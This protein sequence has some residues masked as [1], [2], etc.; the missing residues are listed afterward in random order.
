M[1]AWRHP[2]DRQLCYLSWSPGTWIHH[3]LQ[4]AIL[5]FMCSP[6][7]ASYKACNESDIF[8]SICIGAIVCLYVWCVS[9]RFSSTI[10]VAIVEFCVLLWS[11]TD[12]DVLTDRGV[13]PHQHNLYCIVPT[14]HQ[15]IS[16]PPP[17]FEGGSCRWVTVIVR[18]L[19]LD[20]RSQV[21]PLPSWDCAYRSCDGTLRH[22]IA[23]VPTSC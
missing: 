19:P 23:C 14:Q 12:W 4:E 6:D 7:V 3:V 11:W 13:I 10:F 5:I 20:L 21:T 16:A 18:Q 15:L 22:R 8:Q 1:A 17:S 9:L 2:H